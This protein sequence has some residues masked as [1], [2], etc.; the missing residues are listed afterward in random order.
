MQ[1]IIIALLIVALSKNKVEGMAVGK[2]ASLLN[3]GALIPFFMN[4]KVQFF[5]S[6]FPSFWIGKAMR[7]SVYHLFL[8]SML[9][10]LLWIIVLS[11]KLMRKIVG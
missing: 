5:A 9:I 11:K 10:S 7:R 6:I 1:G 8:V 3:V 2:F 4:S